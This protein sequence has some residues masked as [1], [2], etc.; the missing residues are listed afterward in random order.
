MSDSELLVDF[1]SF[2]EEQTAE[3]IQ[4]LTTGHQKSMVDAEIRQRNLAQENQ[5]DHR[6]VDGLGRLV[7]SFDAEGYLTTRARLGVDAQDDDF[8]KWAIK[9]HPEC[10]VNSGGTKIQVGWNG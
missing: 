3:I 8:V 4:E 10:R 2:T 5:R 6:S 1:S 7:A 9:N